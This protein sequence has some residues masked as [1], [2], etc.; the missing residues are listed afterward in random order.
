VLGDADDQADTRVCGFD[1]RSG[2]GGR[3][4]ENQRCIRTRFGNA[5]GD[6]CVNRQAGNRLP[7]FLSVDPANNFRAILPHESAVELT[8]FPK[9]LHKNLRL[10]IDEEEWLV[11]GGAA[12]KVCGEHPAKVKWSLWLNFLAG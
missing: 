12:H 1:H 9:A 10:L 4:H 6:R 5:F 11:K 7:S 3:W 8:L 2:R